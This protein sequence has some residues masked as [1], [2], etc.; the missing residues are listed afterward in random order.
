M[1]RLIAITRLLLPV[2]LLL[3]SARRDILLAHGGEDHGTVAESPVTVP[4]ATG[5]ELSTSGSTEQFEM[6]LKYSLPTVGDPAP[7]RFFIAEYATNA[8]VTGASFV[9]ASKPSGV[10]FNKVPVM[11]SPGIYQADLNFPGDTVYTLVATVSVGGRTDF[12]ELRNVYAGETAERFLAEHSAGGVPNQ[13]ADTGTSWW[14]WVLAALGAL[15][16]LF[17]VRMV[18][19]RNGAGKGSTTTTEQN[20]SIHEPIEEAK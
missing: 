11:I 3:T 5:G 12:I 17:V 14:V 13:T 2:I 10:V 1:N 19:R 9:L 8:P 18:L 6:L 20:P 15:A 4:T 16:L 7:V